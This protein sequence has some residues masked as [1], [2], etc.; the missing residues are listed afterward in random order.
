LEP[1]VFDR[2]IPYSYFSKTITKADGIFKIG[3]E[4]RRT[5]IGGADRN[6]HESYS[7]IYFDKSQQPVRVENYTKHEFN[8]HIYYPYLIFSIERK[9]DKV[10]ISRTEQNWNE[11]QELIAKDVKIQTFA[12]EDIGDINQLIAAY[13]SHK[14]EFTK[15][16]ESNF[17][18]KRY[19]FSF[20]ANND[21]RNQELQEAIAA[22]AESLMLTGTPAK[23][24]D[25]PIHMYYFSENRGDAAIPLGE[26][27]LVIAQL[28]AVKKNQ[29]E[30]IYVSLDEQKLKEQGR[31]SILQ[32]VYEKKQSE[33]SEN[34]ESLMQ[35]QK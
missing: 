18:D 27:I 13:R 14:N 4:F 22:E 6:K 16:V 10:V 19:F 17:V 26:P 30:F 31:G 8:K 23:N 2:E 20:V 9:V 28:S 25:I 3:A 1:E 34:I 15:F 21:K 5:R 35:N 32:G 7:K 11:K 24:P 12:R 29:L 33:E